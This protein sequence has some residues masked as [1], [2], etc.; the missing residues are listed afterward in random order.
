MLEDTIKIILAD[1]KGLDAAVKKQIIPVIDK[2]LEKI[3]DA[4]LFYY[5]KNFLECVEFDFS[6]T[7][8]YKIVENTF[9]NYEDPTTGLRGKSIFGSLD[10]LFLRTYIACETNGANESTKKST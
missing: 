6:K 3:H 5:H 8:L 2:K 10:N 7:K 9:N 1:N 4:D